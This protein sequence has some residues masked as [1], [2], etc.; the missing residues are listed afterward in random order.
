M[1]TGARGG[2]KQATGSQEN[3]SLGLKHFTRVRGSRIHLKPVEKTFPSLNAQCLSLSAA[4][5]MDDLK[6]N[7][8]VVALF[9]KQC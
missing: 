7:H 4:A 2:R 1:D 6:S 5:K 3:G 8:I 9:L